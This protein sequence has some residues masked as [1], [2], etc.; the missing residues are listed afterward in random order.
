MAEPRTIDNL[1]LGPSIRWAQDQAFI[2]QSI[3][4]ESS[5]VSLQTTIDVSSPFFSS[6][7]DLLFQIKQR[8]APW[9]LMLAP[10]GFNMQKMRL[11]TYQAIPSLGSEEFLSSQMQKIRDKVALNKED[12]MKR[13]EEGRGAEFAWE[14]EREEE[15]EQRESKTLIALLE[16]VHVLD[17]LMAQINAR[18]SQYSKG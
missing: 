8:F 5:F 18:R 9:A 4:K 2:D 13:R 6:E 14:D 12:R 16:Y 17:I 7:F 1:G 10:K 11:F 15:E 3:V